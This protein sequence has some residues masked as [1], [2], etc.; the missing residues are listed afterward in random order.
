M[1]FPVYTPEQVSQLPDKPGVYRFYNQDRQLIYVGKA[2][3]LKKRVSSYFNN[4]SNVD[5]KTRKMVSEIRHIEFTIVNSE[6]DA[7]LLE[8]NVIK[9]HQPKYNIN[10]RDDKTYPY[11]LVTNDRFPRIYATRQLDHSK[12]SYFGPYSN[13]RSMH[14]ILD[15]FRNLYFIRTCKYNLSEE[16]IKKGKIKVCLEY[17][18]GKCKGPC[19]GLQSEADYNKDIDLSKNILKGNINQV[20]NYF[21]DE[22]TAAASKMNF[23]RAQEFKEKLELLENFQLKS[24]VVN[25]KITDVDTFSIVSDEKSAFVNYL[26]I[27]NGAIITAQTVEIKKKLDEAD[28][29]LL[30][31]MIVDLRERHASYSSEILVNIPID[32]ELEKVEIAVPK[33][34]DKKKLIE[35][36]IKNAIFYKKEREK[37]ELEKEP[38]EQRI[39][40]TIQKDLRLKELPIHI[41]CF[42]NSNLQGSNPV[43]SMVCF[44]NTKPSK[45]DYRRFNIKTVEGPNDFAS[46]KEIVKRRYFKLLE[47]SLPMPNLI[48]V[49]GGKGQLSASVEALKELGLYGKIPIVG[50]AKKLEE[51]YFP[52]DPYPLHIN[53]KSESLK[54]LQKIRDEAHRFAITFHRQKRSKTTFTTELDTIKGIGKSTVDKLLGHFRSVKNIKSASLEDLQSLIGKDKARI[55]KEGLNGKGE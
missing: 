52:E 32:L 39:L 26:R 55:V 18:I 20:R 12:G 27:K 44:K 7:L 29:D 31:L 54:L 42:D 28:Q 15:L 8:N 19:E 51:I 38:K 21:K 9:N 35:L 17:H 2:K 53:K 37:Q 25:Q 48:V 49:D 45:T 36:S 34:G 30:A 23:E 24:V 6:F 43:A 14:N 5:R 1:E 33:I 3:S 46:M 16:N 10:L 11:V 13:V 41:E 4:K 47:E 40:K 22:M 50:I